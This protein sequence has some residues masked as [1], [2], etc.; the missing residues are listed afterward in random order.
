MMSLDAMPP[1]VTLRECEHA[2]LDAVLALW[3]AADAVVS[4]T[5]HLDALE[6]RLAHGDGLFLVADAAGRIVGTLIGGWDGWRAGL[7]R[8]AVHPEWR[9]QGIATRLIGEVEGR[10]QRLG[11][12]RISLRVFHES[13]GAVELWSSVGTCRFPRNRCSRRTS[14][15]RPRLVDTPRRAA[16]ASIAVRLRRAN[17]VDREKYAEKRGTESRGR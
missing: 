12:Q 1:A 2:D 5:D 4:P 10:L 14:R 3:R 6:Q 16:V 17:D 8:L 15:S 11:A 13:T 7:Y 9:R